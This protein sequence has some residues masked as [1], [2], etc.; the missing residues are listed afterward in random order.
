MPDVLIGSKRVRSRA[1]HKLHCEKITNHTWRVWGGESEHIVTM[2]E[3]NTFRCDC[4]GALQGFI[5][6]HQARI[7]IEIAPALFTQG[8]HPLGGDPPTYRTIK[9]ILKKN[10]F[11]RGNM[12]RYKE[13]VTFAISRRHYSPEVQ[14]IVAAHVYKFLTSQPKTGK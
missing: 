4:R 8:L 14:E 10:K 2:Q 12:K 1:L 3:D 11:E 9:Y 6:S 5:C 13:A 7:G